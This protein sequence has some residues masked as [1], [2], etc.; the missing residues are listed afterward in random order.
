MKS[1]I[2]GSIAAQLL[3]AASTVSAIRPA[4]REMQG[5]PPLR[6][7]E[8]NAYI[9]SEA[10]ASAASIIERRADKKSPIIAATFDQLIDHENPELGTFKQRYWYNADYYNGPGSPV[11]LNA[12]GENA[13]DGYTGYATNRTLAGSMAQ[14][15]GGLAIVIEHRYWGDSSPYSELTTETLQ[16][17]TLDNAMKDLNYF[18]QNV[19][20][21]F[22]PEG[23]SSPGK[24][25]WVLT[26]CSYSGALTAWIHHLNPGTFWVYHCSS[27]VV[28]VSDALW[29]YW[30]IVEEAMPRN[31]SADVQ[32]VVRYM[33]RTFKSGNETKIQKLKAR[34]GRE[35][36]EDPADFMTGITGVWGQQN[37]QFYT[38][39]NGFHQFCDYVEVCCHLF[40]Y[41]VPCALLT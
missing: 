3:V 19:K 6:A 12:P 24:A 20:F 13:A 35:M 18:A 33:D 41:H 39:Y 22:D 21:P 23:E 36:I 40:S 1:S 9:L 31:C 2:F 32:R 28:E 30:N 11:V 29:Q 16:Y 27:A 4:M 25:P 37:L 8:A 15:I 34:F 38:G 26:G 14:E 17:L 5:A 7:D 10:D